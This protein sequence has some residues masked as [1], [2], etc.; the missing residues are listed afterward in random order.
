VCPTREEAAFYEQYF[1]LTYGIPTAVFHTQ[2]RAQSMSLSQSSLHRLFSTID[3]RANARRLMTDLELYEQYPHHRPQALTARGEAH[4]LQVHLTL[5]GGDPASIRT[6]WSSH[7]VWLN[8][9][10]RLTRDQVQRQGMATRS[11]RGPTWRVERSLRDLGSAMTV[12]DQLA[13]AAGGNEIAFWAKLTSGPKFALHPASHLRPTMRVPVLEE[14]AVVEDEILTIEREPYHGPVYDLNVE[15]LHNYVASG[16]VVHNCIFRWRGADHRALL[17]FPERYPQAALITLDLCHRSTG[18]LVA[19]GNALS[20]LL[21]YRPPLRTDNP[22][23]PFPRLLLAEDEHAEAE[24]VAQQIGALLDRG[25]LPH[26]GEAAVLFRTRAQADVVAGALRATGVPYGLHG[27]ADVF[28]AR[29]VR[30][31]VAY[32]RLGVNP[33]DRAALA[34]IADRP[35]RGLGRLA[36]TLLE[37]PAT[38]AELAGRATDFGPAAVAAAAALMATLYELHAELQRG[39]SAVA[40]LDRALDRSGYR[41]WLERHPEGTSRLRSLARLRALAQRAE[42]PLTQWLDAV[43]IGDEVVSGNDEMVHLSSIHLA[44]GREFRASFVVGAEEGLLPHYRAIR[45]TDAS[46]TALEEELRVCYVALTRARERLFISA[47]RQ[48][49]RGSQTERCDPSRWLAALPPELLA[50]AA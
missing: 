45:S 22:P 47:C 37:E 49:T 20:D 11:G 28:G 41:A 13:Q 24:F 18:H 5:F 8:S 3:T 30:D 7:R 21:A 17:T 36:A 2:G 25:L 46:E 50:P 16:M 35:P 19:V 4:R 29:I 38:T 33:G 40:L 10:H 48:R 26:P 15:N 32:L 9:S 43:A 14:R 12:A 1:S 6:P 31:L 27:H 39:A 23:G 44:K 42:L 34:R